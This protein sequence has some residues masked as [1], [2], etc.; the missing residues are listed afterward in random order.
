VKLPRGQKKIRPWSGTVQS[1][2]TEPNLP[3][4][5]WEVG[6]GEHLRILGDGRLFSV[7][8]A[9]AAVEGRSVAESV[10]PDGS[11][12]LI[13]HSRGARTLLDDL[14]CFAAASQ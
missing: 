7:K 8:A 13:A 5:D 2:I 11:R 14:V 10:W 12:I 6:G 4:G 3:L 1:G 9:A